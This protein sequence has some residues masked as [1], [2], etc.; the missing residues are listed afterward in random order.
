MR[1]GNNKLELDLFLLSILFFCCLFKDFCNFSD[2]CFNKLEILL[3]L[4]ERERER[5]DYFRK[6][7]SRL[8]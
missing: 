1:N 5:I 4:F 3:L 8:D 6:K 7:F 2:C